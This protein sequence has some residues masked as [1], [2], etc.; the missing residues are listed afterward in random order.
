MIFT[1]RPA[2]PG[3]AALPEVGRVFGE[4]LRVT[5]RQL[6]VAG[7]R[8]AVPLPGFPVIARGGEGTGERGR[9]PRVVAGGRQRTEAV[10]GGLVVARFDVDLGAVAQCGSVGRH[11]PQAGVEPGTGRW[12]VVLGVPHQAAPVVERGNGERRAALELVPG[13]GEQALRLGY[14]AVLGMEHRQCAQRRETGPVPRG[15]AVQFPGFGPGSGR[16]QELRPVGRQQDAIQAAVFRRLEVGERLGE[17]VEDRSRPGPGQQGRA[18]VGRAADE[19]PGEFRRP[20]VVGDAAKDMAAQEEQVD[21]GQ[22]FGRRL[23][24]R[25]RDPRGQPVDPGVQVR[26]GDGAAGGDWF[27]RGHTAVQH[28]TIRG[29]QVPPSIGLWAALMPRPESPE[30]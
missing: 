1:A 25:V 23:R 14:L 22:R 13:R 3:L 6:V 21:E 15:R 18:V 4:G 9:V 28:R 11:A 2:R 7:R 27:C 20:L 19:L 17:A 26:H 8:A 29:G 10:D 12:Q 16:L 5:S 24:G 30:R